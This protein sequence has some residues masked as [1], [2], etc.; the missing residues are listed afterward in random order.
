VSAE[1][2]GTKEI[3]K[4]AKRIMRDKRGVKA[5]VRDMSYQEI[6]LYIEYIDYLKDIYEEA[7]KL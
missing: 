4:E 2:R 1:R 6:A 7:G 3:R 5:D